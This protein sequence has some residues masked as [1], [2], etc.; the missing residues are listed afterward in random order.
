MN[1]IERLKQAIRD[2]HG[3]DS[4]HVQ[5]IF[6]HETF[7]GKVVWDGDVEE[8]RLID[9]P[10]AKTGFAWSYKNDAG[11]TRYVAIL[12]V[13]PVDTAVNAVR[14]YIVAEAQKQK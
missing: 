10:K 4:A 11:E 1:E 6:A 13:P 9:H 14:A 8:F 12:G 7:Q 5:T 3:C 2:L